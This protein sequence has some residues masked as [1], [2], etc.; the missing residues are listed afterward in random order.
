M[1][2]RPFIA[3]VTVSL[4]CFG[5]PAF[6]GPVRIVSSLPDLASIA[7]AIGGDRV[8]VFSIAKATANP[9]SI[10]VFPS[11]MAR[12]AGASIYLKCGLGLDQWSDAI[13]DGSRNAAVLSVDCSNGIPV[14]EKPA[15]RVDAS[16][17][18]VHPYGNPH[19]W[20]NP[21]N[22]VIIAGNILAGLRKVDP[23][24]GR[25]YEERFVQF[26]KECRDRMAG[27]REKLKPFSGSP[28][29]TYHSSWAYFAD[30]FGF[31]IVGKIEP[32]PGIPPSGQP[33]RRTRFADTAGEGAVRDPGALFLR[34]RPAVP[35]PSDRNYGDQSCAVLY[36]YESDVLFRTLR[37]AG[38]SGRPGGRELNMLLFH[39]SFM[40]PAL[41]VCLV[42][43]GIHT[44]FGYHI[45]RRGVIFVDL[46]L[47]QI[48]ALGASV[49]ILLGWGE[50]A[51]ALNY[52]VSLA[53]TLGGAVLFAFLRRSQK[54]APM[55]A[56]IGITYAGAIALSLLVLEK[57]AT[58]TEHIKEMLV[59][60]I[61]TVSWR[62]VSLLAGVIGAIGIVHLFFRK[63]F[64]LISADPEGAAARNMRIWRWDVL[65]YATFGIAVTA[66]VKVAGVLLIFSLLV[67]PAVTAMIGVVGTGR[68]I[69]FGW[70]F[71][72]AGCAL[73]LEFSLRGDFA[74]G[75]SI[76]CTMLLLLLL[77]ASA[78]ALVKK[79]RAKREGRDE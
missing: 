20:L 31:R 1:K 33:P 55:E 64:L 28:I 51:P 6:S 77:C 59:G 76:I 11:Y 35:A 66:S 63:N 21:E 62:E 70:V 15:G 36:R 72:L 53:F 44:Y 3:A 56:L 17:G 18:D 38:A 78:A 49:G 57:S 47:S 37:F 43:A 19:Y 50:N 25:F 54:T 22:G 42:L 8:S 41:A 61:L 68:R 60:T 14:L 27:W 75:P 16:M 65:F 24:N 34:R 79:C 39:Y 58:G 52:A 74:A 29:I 48:A 10:E 40:L 67:I 2:F 23:S 69:V 5:V 30:C 45:V 46:S 73:G 9:H 4:L 12:V 13:I 26:E 32:F 7:A 71:G